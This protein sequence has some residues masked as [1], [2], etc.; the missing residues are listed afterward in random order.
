MLL[1]ARFWSPTSG[2]LLLAANFAPLLLAD[3][4]WLHTTDH[5]LLATSTGRRLLAAEYWPPTARSLLLAAYYWPPADLQAV[6]M[7]G[8][9]RGKA[10]TSLRGPR[11]VSGG[12]VEMRPNERRTCRRRLAPGAVAPA[13][14]RARARACRSRARASAIR[15]DPHG[16]EWVRALSLAFSRPHHDPHA[17]EAPPTRRRGSWRFC[18]G[19][20][21]CGARPGLGD[22]CCAN[23]GRLVSAGAAALRSGGPAGGRT[24]GRATG[25]AS[26]GR[27]GRRADGPASLWVRRRAGG[28]ADDLQAQERKS[29]ESMWPC[30]R[31]HKATC[32]LDQQGGARRRRGANTPESVNGPQAWL[33]NTSARAHTHTPPQQSEPE[34][35]LWHK[36]PSLARPFQAKPSFRRTPM[37]NCGPAACDPLLDLP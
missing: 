13:A 21:G 36:S 33:T 7:K 26:G 23:H 8:A 6:T 12:V 3:Y 31:K 10:S 5:L 19:R 20:C 9:D 34:A 18:R 2:R 37:P 27:T 16:N 28:W 4:R 30:R 25:P 17:A 24:G 1:T 22:S 29:C 11:S 35:P 32:R 15:V 14:P